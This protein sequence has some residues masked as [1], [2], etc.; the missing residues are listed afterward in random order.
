MT[1]LRTPVW[2]A[3]VPRGSFGQPIGSYCIRIREREVAP[4]LL[5]RPAERGAIRIVEIINVAGI[6]LQGRTEHWV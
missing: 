5:F 3:D 1:L 6:R 4:G 2:L